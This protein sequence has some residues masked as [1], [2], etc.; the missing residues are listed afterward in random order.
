MKASNFGIFILLI[1]AN[2]WGVSQELA[3][4]DFKMLR[5]KENYR[6][7]SRTQTTLWQKIKYISLGKNPDAYLSIG[8]D[9]RSEFQ[10][11]QNE[12]WRANQDED[13]TLFQRFMLHTDWRFNKNIRLFAQLKNG[14]TIDRRIEPFFLDEDEIDI[15]QLF[16]ELNFGK[17]QL[18]LGRKELWYGSRRL[19]SVREGTNIRQSFDG[20]RLIRKDKKHQTDFLFYLYN[21]QEIRAFDNDINDDRLLW[22]IYHVWNINKSN[23]LDLYYLGVDNDANTTRFEEASAKETRHSVGARHWGNKGN[24]RYNNEAL[25]QF[26]TFGEKD[27][28]AWTASTEMY[29]RLSPKR[30]KPTVGL[31]FDIISGDNDA[32][33]NQMQTFNALYPRG[34]YFGLLALIGPANLIDVHPSFRISPIKK[35]N[36]NLDWDIFWRYSLND[37]IYFPSSRLNIP[38]SNSQNSFIGHQFGIQIDYGINRFME[39]EISCFYFSAGSF[40]DDALQEEINENAS[41]VLQIGAS[42]N[43]KF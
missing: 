2:L 27:I 22:G 37:G 9:I 6:F 38:S 3:V 26:G 19:I 11:F 4:P 1:F 12:E 20:G 13:G 7:L 36:V 41:D 29:Y 18:Q 10:T 24:F 5:A 43:C 34:G 23:N 31:K 17:Y 42:F 8:G 14:F 25:I 40:L 28:L 32:E 16:L 35:L 39:A 30:A 15:H 33:D 21:P